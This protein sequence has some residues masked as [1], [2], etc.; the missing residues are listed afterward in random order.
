MIMRSITT[1]CKEGKAHLYSSYQGGVFELEAGA[2]LCI[3]VSETHAR[4]I[5]MGESASFFGAFMI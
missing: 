5:S 4:A 1:R 3:G 2:Q